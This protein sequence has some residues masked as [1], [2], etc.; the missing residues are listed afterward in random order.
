MR[1]LYLVII[2]LVSFAHLSARA[3]A[4]TLTVTAGGT[5]RQFTDDELRASPNAAMIEVRWTPIVRQP[6]PCSKV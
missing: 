5:A 2:L 6:E 3:A 4:P 1:V